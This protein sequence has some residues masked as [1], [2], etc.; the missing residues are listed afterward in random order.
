MSDHA[1][2]AALRDHQY[3]AYAE[4]S[5]TSDWLPFIRAVVRA[6][7]R[8]RGLPLDAFPPGPWA[9]PPGLDLS[10]ASPYLIGALYNALQAD[11]H[12][13]G[14]YYTPPGLARNL[15]AQ[16]L[17]AVPITPAP[18]ILDPAAGA[19]AFLIAAAETLRSRGL[20][21]RTALACLTGVDLDADALE[22]ARL[23]LWLW[24]SD[25]G[26][27]LDDLPVTLLQADTLR[28]TP[29]ELELPCDALLGNPPY[30]SVFTRS[31]DEAPLN[32]YETAKGAY[33]LAVPFVERAVTLTRPGGQIGLVLPNKLL[34]ARYADTL[35]GW[36]AK[37]VTI[38][39]IEEGAEG[40]FDADVYPVLIHMQRTTPQ[41]AAP[42]TITSSDGAAHTVTQ[43]D[44]H[45]A[46]GGTWWPVM[47]PGWA[48]LR[49]YFET[50]LTLGEIVEMHAGL[51]VAEAYALRDRVIECPLP[52]PGPH[53]FRLLVSGAIHPFYTTW[54][55]NKTRFLKRAYQRPVIPEVAL[56][57]RRQAHARAAKVIVAGLSRAPRACLDPGLSQASVSTT[58]IVGGRWP[59][60]A[61]CGLLNSTLFGRLYRAMF[62]GL[63][64]SG[65]YLRVGKNELAALPVPDLPADDP[66]VG[67]L[68][69]LA[70]LPDAIARDRTLDALVES[71]YT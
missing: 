22:V 52:T 64:L 4:A 21:R 44:L 48:D 9:P 51:T 23:G 17:D 42:I 29:S 63:A 34:A 32:G 67:Q 5:G 12:Q 14:A 61:V 45:H 41:P 65:G 20:D 56:P 11:R 49:G 26:L 53:D 31:G 15:A 27:A 57:A 43:S 25:P 18:R 37:R 71:L 40:L 68:D 46:P 66:R 19:G 13:Q 33:D 39:G 58:I 60:G 55:R 62:G 7:A 2:L 10:A 8:T 54:G 50:G 16:T 36:L 59:L 38:L 1:L 69:T 70:R 30:A 28:E 35:R 47:D 6:Q 3:P 24:A